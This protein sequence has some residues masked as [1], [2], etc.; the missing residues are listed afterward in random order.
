M[1][2]CIDLPDLFDSL[3]RRAKKL[4]RNHPL[5]RRA[6]AERP[7]LRSVLEKV[8]V[9]VVPEGEI[10]RLTG[11]DICGLHYWM[12]E[13]GNARSVGIFVEDGDGAYRTLIHEA[14][15]AKVAEKYPEIFPYLSYETSEVLA[16]L[17]VHRKGPFG[18][19]VNPRLEDEISGLTM[20]EGVRE[21]FKDAIW[22][23]GREKC[24]VADRKAKV[25]L[26]RAIDAVLEKAME[27]D[28][29]D[30]ADREELREAA[31]KAK[32]LC[33]ESKM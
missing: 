29:L 10:R 11:Q 23:L 26:N 14:C 33:M 30:F 5:I 1:R 16:E 8:P 19:G 31:E 12:H 25:G 32:S 18:M 15:H 21:A 27:M 28:M 24:D 20:R 3:S 4:D 9:G 13:N 17:C 2:Q 7:D 6:F 22:R